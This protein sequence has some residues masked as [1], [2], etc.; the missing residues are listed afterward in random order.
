MS[1][2]VSAFDPAA[3]DE[4]DSLDDLVRPRPPDENPLT[5]DSTSSD[6][7]THREQWGRG[8]QPAADTTATDPPATASDARSDAE[9]GRVPPRSQAF[10]QVH[11]RLPVRLV[12]AL[13]EA[14]A[15]HRLTH[16]EFLVAALAEYRAA[17]P[18]LLAS[19]T[20]AATATED[21]GFPALSSPRSKREL[22]ATRMWRL[23]RSLVEWL[24]H[25]AQQPDLGGVTRSQILIAVLE[26]GLR[27]GASTAQVAERAHGTR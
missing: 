11:V 18:D 23:R 3:L 8:E 21:D 13:L 2:R 26:A 1:R 27:D 24:E 16:T 5:A 22:T 9:G 20:S 4:L 6:E 15:T 17:L 12:E 14:A 7:V 10:V 19:T 25:R